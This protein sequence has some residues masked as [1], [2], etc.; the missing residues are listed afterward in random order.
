M[1]AS[2]VTPKGWLKCDGKAYNKT[3]YPSL[4]KAIGDTYRKP[5]TPESMFNVPDTQNRYPIGE[6]I[7]Y[8]T[9]MYVEEQLPNIRGKFAIAGTENGAGSYSGSFV[10]AGSKSTNGWQSHGQGGNTPPLTGFDASKTLDASGKTI[11]N[12]AYKDPVNG[13]PV[14]VRPNSVVM[15]YIIKAK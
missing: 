12:P 2:N 10:N 1:G 13:V 5:E 7:D 15:N 6:S 9:G 11:D 8:N 3:D 4:F 14:K